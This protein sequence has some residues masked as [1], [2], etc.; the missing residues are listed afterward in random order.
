MVP[1]ATIID[2]LD[3]ELEI[4]GF[5]DHCPNGLQVPSDRP[6]ST[7]A[8]GVSASLE[9]STAPAMPAPSSSLPTMACSGTFIRAR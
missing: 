7:V 9:L 6:V 8:T 3:A 2:F 1:L 5:E 4:D